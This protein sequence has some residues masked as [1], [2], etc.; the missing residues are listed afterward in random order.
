MRIRQFVTFVFAAGI[1]LHTSA[2]TASGRSTLLDALEARYRSAQAPSWTVQ[3]DGITAGPVGAVGFIDN[4]IVDGK[5]QPQ[6][7]WDKMTT[8]V[9]TRAL[10]V[11]EPVFVSKIDAKNDQVRLTLVTYDTYDAYP[12][13]QASQYTAVLSFRF[14]ESASAVSLTRHLDRAEPQHVERA[15]EAIVAPYG[16]QPNPASTGGAEPAVTPTAPSAPEV[17]PNAITVTLGQTIDQVTAALGSPEKI[18]NLGTKKI[19]LYKAL[20]VTFLDGK[21]SDVE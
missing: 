14:T 18:I 10:S 6:G 5:I 12:G 15:I 17:H 19:L 13:Y 7:R 21:V 3:Q 1:L 9:P 11:G 4:K 8:W 16:G 20:K 2:L